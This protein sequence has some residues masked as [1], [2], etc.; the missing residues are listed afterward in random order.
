MARVIVDTDEESFEED[1]EDCDKSLV[2]ED[3]QDYIESFETGYMARRVKRTRE[4]DDGNKD[5]PTRKAKE[6]RT[7]K[8]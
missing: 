1:G 7:V 5:A 8:P 2:S 4:T 6:G 3:N